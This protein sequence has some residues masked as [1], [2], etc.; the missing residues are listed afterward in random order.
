MTSTI[1]N[2]KPVII[3][4]SDKE[5]K[6]TLSNIRSALDVIASHTSTFLQV[7]NKLEISSQNVGF[8]AA[9]MAPN[10]LTIRS[11]DTGS[12]LTASI[13]KSST[14]QGAG[15]AEVGV[16]KIPRSVFKNKQ[17]IALYSF[18]F[19][20]DILFGNKELKTTG[21]NILSATIVNRKLDNLLSPI[22]ITFKAGSAVGNQFPNCSFWD[23]VT[24][25]HSELTL[26]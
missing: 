7:D 2:T 14:N 12:Q 6:N 5:N 26:N 10:D 15:G 25:I 13:S 22:N 24:G 17:N 18:S 4:E 9:K 16:M 1:A 20:Q 19:R 21:S 11:E 23:E 8:A 3:S